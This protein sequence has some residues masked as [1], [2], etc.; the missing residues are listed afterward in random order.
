MW[1]WLVQSFR[2]KIRKDSIRRKDIP[3]YIVGFE[4]FDKEFI[5]VARLIQV[6]VAKAKPA[7]LAR[8]VGMKVPESQGSDQKPVDL[9]VG[10]AKSRETGMEAR[11]PC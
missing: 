4:T 3:S 7:Q 9:A 1:I 8:R 2:R 10:S 6:A 5:F 11:Y